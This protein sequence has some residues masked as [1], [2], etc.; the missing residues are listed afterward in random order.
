MSKSLP[1]KRTKRNAMGFRVQS[2]L[3]VKARHQSFNKLC[4]RLHLSA[5][6]TGNAGDIAGLLLSS[7]LL[8]LYIRFR[9]PPPSPPLL[10]QLQLSTRAKVLKRCRVHTWIVPWTA[11]RVRCSNKDESGVS[12]RIPCFRF[13]PWCSDY[14]KKRRRNC[15]KGGT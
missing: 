3:F 11:C 15:K 9:P 1:L 10:P 12:T 14:E 5:Y 7:S 2:F 6:L 8:L 4:W 13:Y